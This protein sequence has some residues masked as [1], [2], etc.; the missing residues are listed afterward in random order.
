MCTHVHPS[1]VWH[2]HGM[3]TQVLFSLGP[4]S[5][6]G[7]AAAM[8]L[9]VSRVGERAGQTELLESEVREL[10]ASFLG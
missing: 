10:R 1:C 5:F 3:Y 9:G 7:S 8:Q 6:S 2:V 4:S